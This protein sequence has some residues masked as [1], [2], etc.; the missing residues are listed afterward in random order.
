MVTSGLNYG[1]FCYDIGLCG[2]TTDGSQLVV[3]VLASF[4]GHVKDLS[5]PLPSTITVRKRPPL[6]RV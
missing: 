4:L 6:L 3:V 5:F 2:E 1:C